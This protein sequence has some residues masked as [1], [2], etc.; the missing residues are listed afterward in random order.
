MTHE[1]FV[2]ARGRDLVDVKVLDRAIYTLMFN[3]S[4]RFP[5]GYRYGYL[6]GICVWFSCFIL[7][8]ASLVW[9]NIWAALC[10]VAAGIFMRRITK[11]T[12]IDIIVKHAF[13]NKEFYE[14]STE[15]SV[16]LVEAKK[17]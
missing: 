3:P 10:L 2:Q 9:W 13:D 16:I 5:T 4:S 14:A 17:Q 15:R 12:A 11:Q 7:A 8:F 1:E 6:F